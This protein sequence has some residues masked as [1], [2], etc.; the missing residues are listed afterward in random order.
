M[1]CAQC[2]DESG[3]LLARRARVHHSAPRG[4][5]DSMPSWS[6]FSS[7]VRGVAGT[8]PRDDDDASDASAFKRSRRVLLMEALST[9]V[10]EGSPAPHGDAPLQ[11]LRARAAP[12]PYQK[13][14]DAP[15]ATNAAAAA[16]PH[17][18]PRPLQRARPPDAPSIRK[19]QP[20]G[21][22]G[23]ASKVI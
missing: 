6:G 5:A 12:Q 16:L 1:R 3:R 10:N 9:R 14:D 13:G 23:D 7:N 17:G 2:L 8:P 15:P 20:L 22:A 11:P 18:V 4:T 19:E 21:P